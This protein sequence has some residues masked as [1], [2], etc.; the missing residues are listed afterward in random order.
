[1]TP[2]PPGL[3]VAELDRG[4]PLRCQ[5]RGAARDQLLHE[6]QAVESFLPLLNAGERPGARHVRLERS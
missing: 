4:D 3:G 1:M 5:P 2:S 6:Y